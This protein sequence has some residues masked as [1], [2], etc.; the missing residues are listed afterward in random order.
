MNE[1]RTEDRA[2][3]AQT[4][5]SSRRN[6]LSIASAW[7]LGAIILMVIAWPLVLK[8]ASY[9]GPKATEFARQHQ[10]DQLSTEQ[11]RPPSATH[12]FGTDVHGR[13][14][15]SRVLYGAQFS[16]LVGIVGAGVSLVIGVFWGATAG[17]AGG[18]L[19]GM[20]MR[21]V[22]VLYSM[23]SI[24]LVIVLVTTLEDA[25]KKGLASIGA[26]NLSNSARLLF[27][28]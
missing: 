11:F 19:D 3:M 7:V 27:L 15:F 17:Y 24:I 21:I 23:P 4:K 6:R 1:A 12:W 13:D 25:F 8:L 5:K 26:P 9:A 28:F 10:P 2:S 20:M 14:L 22:D 18:R 16:F